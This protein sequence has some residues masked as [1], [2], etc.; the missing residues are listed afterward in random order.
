MGLA[1]GK[2]T[3]PNTEYSILRPSFGTLHDFHGLL[4]QSLDRYYITA[5][6]LLPKKLFVYKILKL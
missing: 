5:K 1:S 4:Y 2:I 3:N 6:L